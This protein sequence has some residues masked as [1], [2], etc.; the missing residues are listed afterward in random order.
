[1]TIPAAPRPLTDRSRKLWR[2]VLGQYELSDAELAV[3]EQALR[4]LDRADQAAEVLTKEGLM[5]VDRYGATRSHPAVDI[6]L[7][8]RTTFARLIGQLGVKLPAETPGPRRGA[9]AG[10]R[11]NVARRRSG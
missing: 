6:E 11:E 2:A 9:R 5:T 3:L 7:R 4:S 8:H 1:M 10:R